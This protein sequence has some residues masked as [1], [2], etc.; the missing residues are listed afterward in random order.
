MV[1]VPKPAG[2]ILALAPAT[3][4][5]RT[6]Y[7]KVIIRAAESQTRSSSALTQLARRCFADAAPVSSRLLR[8]PPATDRFLISASSTI[9]PAGAALIGSPKISVILRTVA[10]R[11]FGRVFVG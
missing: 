4:R 1:E 3:I 8:L 5:F 9:R 11:W 7:Y 6:L 10:D 2:V